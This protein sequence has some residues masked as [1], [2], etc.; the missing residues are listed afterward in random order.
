MLQM[1]EFSSRILTKVPTGRE[2]REKRK[3]TMSLL[4]SANSTRGALVSTRSFML[5]AVVGAVAILEV[6]PD[7]VTCSGVKEGVAELTN[8]R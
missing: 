8:Q 2:R 1:E 5:S 3:S 7:S 4:A 6:V